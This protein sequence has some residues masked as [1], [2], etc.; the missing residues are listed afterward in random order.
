MTPSAA[1]L[2]AAS[3]RAA[4]GR[5]DQHRP[6]PIGATL[7]LPRN[8]EAQWEAGM[9]HRLRLRIPG[10]D[11]QRFRRALDHV[12]AAV[13]ALQFAVR[14]AD[15]RCLFIPAI[16]PVIELADAGELAVADDQHPV[17]YAHRPQNLPDEVELSI[18][19]HLVDRSCWGTIL[20]LLATAYNTDRAVEGAEQPG[21][22]YGD[23]CHRQARQRDP[24]SS[25]SAVG[26]ALPPSSGAQPLLRAHAGSPYGVLATELGHRSAPTDLVAQAIRALH[27]C[28]WRSGTTTV[29]G[30][31]AG[32]PGVIGTSAE[33]GV[34]RHVTDDPAVTDPTCRPRSC[35]LAV[36]TID[37]PVLRFGAIEA[38]LLVLPSGAGILDI[39]LV[40]YGERNQLVIGGPQALLGGYTRLLVEQCSA[41][42]AVPAD[43]TLPAH[44]S[45]SSS[46]SAVDVS[47]LPAPGIR[48]VGR[49]LSPAVVEA[50]VRRRTAEL[51]AAGVGTGTGV[52]IELPPGP[53]LV[54]NL[55]AAVRCDAAVLLLDPEDP[56]GW[57]DDLGHDMAGAVR[58][59]R[60]NRVTAPDVRT[61]AETPG[62]R[63]ALSAAPGRRTTAIVGWQELGAAAPTL[64]ELWSV[65]DDP[66]VLN[67]PVAGE[68][69]VLRC[70]AA[71]AAGVDLLVPRDEA[72]LAD[73]V[74]SV[75]PA[76][77]ELHPGQS[78]R[79]P[80][81]QFTPRVWSARSCLRPGSPPRTA[82]T[83]TRWWVAESPAAICIGAEN[84][85][86][87]LVTGFRIVGADG[88]PV[89]PGAVGDLRIPVGSTAGYDQDP[90]QTA[91][92]FRPCC[93]GAR[94]LRSGAVA[95]STGD[96]F[97]IIEPDPDRTVCD[98]RTVLLDP[99]RVAIGVGV[100]GVGVVGVQ[101]P[102]QFGDDAAASDDA[103]RCW[104]IVPDPADLPGLQDL[105]APLQEP[106]LVGDPRAAD[107][108]PEAA[109]ARVTQAI[110]RA[111][112]GAPPEPPTTPTE[113]AL[114]EQ[115]VLPVLG[116]AV[117]RDDNLFALGATSLQLVRISLQVRESTGA[118]VPLG[119]LFGN[120]TLR[121]LATV[122]DEDHARSGR[123][124]PGDGT[125]EQH[126]TDLAAALDL[127]D[128]VDSTASNEGDED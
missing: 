69:F 120:P 3:R 26:A 42:T 79:L 112:D 82:A 83:V 102:D 59:D 47:A 37:L 19:A 119:R 99:L 50:A 74:G 81:A 34:T 71:G 113:R 100:V 67:A 70:L 106:W 18:G 87:P 65:V 98:G 10:L 111:A 21:L 56:P 31:S 104:A 117:G 122:V 85:L 7:P 126:G 45:T 6:R 93:G 17:R 35:D 64:I 123:S 38:E 58:V 61:A 97:R 20:R 103:E 40:R 114:A 95:V 86:R 68:D 28:G 118:D 94:E 41:T 75:V 88:R 84:D 109:R 54:A 32:E 66:I 63:L 39:C 46:S 14:V 78:D 2:K 48:T 36:S 49:A 16:E 62:L 121:A 29:G 91:D 77:I 92:R 43:F 76:C 25:D 8:A 125:D 30:W 90:R 116:M 13:E 73:L 108:S 4:V 72:E 107:L 22:R 55:F 24:D 57:R 9:V 51:R 11:R 23:H 127:L 44:A 53:E 12:T 33:F 1:L 5:R 128:E 96:G 80:L 60:A 27:R 115:A 124:A 89:P 105:P 101:A 15:G 110:A 52:A